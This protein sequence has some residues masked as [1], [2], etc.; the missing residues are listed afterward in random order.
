[1]PC[2]SV[3]RIKDQL[4]FATVFHAAAHRT[5]KRDHAGRARHAARATQVR[6]NQ[7]TCKDGGQAKKQKK[8]A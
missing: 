7:S 1:M 2:R 6:P 4:V 5:N 8:N 3:K